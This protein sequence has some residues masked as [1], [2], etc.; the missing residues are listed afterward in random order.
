MLE[1]AR[2]QTMQDLAT[3][4]RDPMVRTI[5]ATVAIC[6]TVTLFLAGRRRKRLSYSL[7]DTRVLGIHEGVNP[8][9]VQILFD[10]EPVKEVHLV[11]ITINNLGNEPVRADDFE[12]PMRFSWPEPARILTAEVMEVSPETLQP[13]I[14]AGPGEIALDPLLL[15]PGDW[16]RMRALINQAGK[17]FVDA[18][19]VGVR[20]IN[21]VNTSE[22][23]RSATPRSFAIM[24]A[25][26]AGAVLLI[27]A[28][29]KLG[30][31]I[32]DGQAEERITLTVLVVMLLIM[33][34]WLKSAVSD[35]ISNF[36]NKNGQK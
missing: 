13:R 3:I 31:W 5:L 16:L 36:K 20:R 30:L 18:R 22:K 15:N 9:R 26:G 7:S 29:Q 6:V 2:R 35:L 23:A 34:D 19:V 11:T 8:S 24:G 28:G 4:L 33:S 25:L 1:P 14:K 17:L 12:R 32:A 21:K 10:G 27:E